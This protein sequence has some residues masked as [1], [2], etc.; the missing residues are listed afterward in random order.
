MTDFIA[1]YRGK[2]VAEAEL[3]AVSADTQLVRR[4]FAHLLG[5][6]TEDEETRVLEAN[7]QAVLE[8]VRGD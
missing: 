1:L 3:V 5:E 2:T 6:H 4:F 8:L 7:H